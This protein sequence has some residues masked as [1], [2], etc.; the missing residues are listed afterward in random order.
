MITIFCGLGLV[1]FVFVLRRSVPTPLKR[2]AGKRQ[3]T[4]F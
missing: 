2:R 1:M 3:A 4:F